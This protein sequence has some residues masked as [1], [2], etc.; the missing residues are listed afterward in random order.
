MSEVG[1]RYGSANKGKDEW[2]TPENAVKSILPYI[3]G[4]ARCIVHSIPRKA[5]L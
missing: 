3:R 5:N 1:A 2:Y 4:G